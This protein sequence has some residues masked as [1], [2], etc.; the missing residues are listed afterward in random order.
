MWHLDVRYY[1]TRDVRDME[2]QVGYRSLEWNWPKEAMNMT[3]GVGIVDGAK[4]F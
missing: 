3:I 4:V 2:Q 1:A